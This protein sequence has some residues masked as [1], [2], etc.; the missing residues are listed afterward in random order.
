MKNADFKYLLAN[1]DSELNVDIEDPN[2]LLL[3]MK[4]K[5][6]DNDNRTITSLIQNIVV[7]TLLIDK[8]TR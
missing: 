7:G 3:V 1:M 6:D 8:D 5:L 2:Q 4:S